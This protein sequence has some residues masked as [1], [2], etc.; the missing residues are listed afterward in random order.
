ME[1][2]I[3]L[4][5]AAFLHSKY[6]RLYT[7]SQSKNAYATMEKSNRKQDPLLGG[8]EAEYDTDWFGDDGVGLPAAMA[9]VR[10]YV[11]T[12][13]NCED[14]A[15]QMVREGVSGANVT[16]PNIRVPEMVGRGTR[17]TKFPG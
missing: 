15:M 12:N 13:R 17:R 9:E 3:V 1:Y 4:T 6:L 11:N 2:S 16:V 5:K 14:I 8:D 7:G 10:T